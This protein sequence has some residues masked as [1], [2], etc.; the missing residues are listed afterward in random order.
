MWLRPRPFSQTF[1]RNPC[2]ETTVPLWCWFR[3]SKWDVM[4][5][6]VVCVPKWWILFAFSLDSSWL[7]FDIFQSTWHQCTRFNGDLINLDVS[8][9]FLH[10]IKNSMWQRRSRHY[11]SN[12]SRS[13]AT[14]PKGFPFGRI[15]TFTIVN[16]PWT[17]PKDEKYALRFWSYAHVVADLPQGSCKQNK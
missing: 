17:N 7:L 16:H 5:K 14:W 13:L 12:W 4:I 8:H 2:S 11:A 15:V 10:S 3:S 9:D 1:I 6:A